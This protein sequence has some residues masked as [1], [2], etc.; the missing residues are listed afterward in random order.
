M[1]TLKNIF[2]I[3]EVALGLGFVIF[4]HELGHFVLAKWNGV[5]VEKF[6]IGFGPTLLGF[7]RGETEYVLAVLPFGGFVKM[8]GEGPEEEANKSSDPRAYPN[9]SVRARM[10]IISAGVIMNVLLG[11][12]CFV[13][14]YKQ[15][16]DEMPT[17]IGA[18]VAGM[19]AYEAGFLPGDE[20]V[21]IDGRRDLS[22]NNLKMRVSLSS[23]G[24]KLRFEVKRPGV[25]EPKFFDLE[26][27][28]DA[29]NKMPEIGI[30]PSIGLTLD[31]EK[32]F[33][34]PAGLEAKPKDPNDGLLPGGT[35]V[36]AGPVGSTPVPVADLPALYR[37]FGKAMDK[38]FDIVVERRPKG[39]AI[40]AAPLEKKTAVLL[41]NHFVEFGFRLAIE[42]ITAIRKDSPA[43]VAD[44]RKGD[45]IIKVDGRDDFDPMRLPSECFEKA[46]KPMTFEVER[47]DPGRGF[48]NRDADRDARSPRALG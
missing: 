27:L 16:I 24:Q 22:F 20:I 14:V 43:Y 18:V 19:P 35:V 41:P 10:A 4:L 1:E 23:K 7:T 28:R 2:S 30:A 12:A 34:A 25:D 39:E 40:S 38:P 9:K 17:T 3:A 37:E 21:A 8:L 5:K 31:D 44:F 11:L 6:S 29:G 48:E 13:Y 47:S 15:G 26:P 46:G 45:R 32:P 42:P 33:L 36:A